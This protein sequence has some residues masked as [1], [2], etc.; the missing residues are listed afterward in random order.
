M[1]TLGV[2]V[3]ALLYPQQGDLERAW[4]L[5]G[6][7]DR[8]QAIQLLEHTVRQFPNNSDARLLLGS[9]LSEAGDAPEAIDQLTAAVRLAP[10]SADAQNALG[11]AYLAAGDFKDARSPFEQALKLKPQYAIAQ[12]NLGSVLLQ[13]GDFN[14][15]AAHL[16]RAI[17]LL[18]RDAD[19]AY[20]RYLRAKAYSAASDPQNAAKLLEQAIALRPEY[21]EAWSDLGQARR[22]LLDDAGALAAEKRAVELKPSDPVAQYRLG[23]E[24]L[25]QDQIDAAIEHLQTANQLKPGDQSTLNALQSALRQ[26]GRSAE[27]DEIKR[28]LADLLR[29]KDRQNQDELEA[30]KLNNEG[31][32]LQRAGHLAE[33]AA[34]YKQAVALYPAHAG[35]RVNYAVALLRLGRW[36]DGLNELH[37]ALERDPGNAQIR[38]ALNDA[39]RQAPAGTRP[40]WADR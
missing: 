20:A 24:Y 40:A 34:K 32:D 39:L 17:E 22:L 15:A 7:G 29:E 1:G 26:A 30:V 10:R 11:E 12:L 5:A 35:I 4:N 16:D 9:L 25:R 14:A 37:E 6:N 19:A 8:S 23:A 38:S 33:A 3:F 36:T 18:G 28:R 21:A 31:A 13:A 2:I 27:A